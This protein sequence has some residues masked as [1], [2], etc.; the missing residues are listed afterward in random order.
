M[1]TTVARRARV[2]EGDVVAFLEDK[3]F[4]TLRRIDTQA[5]HIFLTED[6]AWKIKRP[7]D[8]GFLDFSSP[9]KRRQALEAELELNRRTAPDLYLGVHA[10]TRDISGKLALNGTG[11]AVDWVLE[12]RRFSDD[13]LLD[14]RAENHALNFDLL[15]RVADAVQRF[16]D[17]AEIAW[18]AVPEDDLRAVISGNDA[19]FEATTAVLLRERTTALTRAH[20]TM[21]RQC[22]PLLGVR[23]ARG[24]V[25]HVHGDL[26]LRNIAVIDGH[27]LLFDCLESDTRL[28]TIDVTYDLSFLLMDLWH[29]GLCNEANA[30]YNRYVDLSPEDED[31]GAL[32]PLF[33]SLRAAIRAH[34]LATQAL[35]GDD[36]AGLQAR[37]YLDQAIDLIRPVKPCLIALGGL[38]GTGK[39]TL[40]RSLGGLVGSAPGARI[41]R[42]DVLRK[43]AAG[44]KP[45]QSLPRSTYTPA[46]AQKSYTRL[47]DA[48]ARQLENGVS[49]IVD[50]AFAEAEQRQAIVQVADRADAPFEGLWL[51][52][53][54]ET[55]LQRVRRRAHDASDADEAVARMQRDADLEDAGPWRTLVTNGAPEQVAADARGLLHQSLT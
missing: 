44:L 31:A 30:V 27:T 53:G 34:V 54:I 43:R 35:Q 2:D 41:L 40:A 49:V 12:M 46:A 22:E 19:R 23:A 45:E 26:H 11:E 18:D 24:R 5:A 1:A 38:S 55:R 42:S 21:L 47:A 20:R 3:A 14:R 29:R 8:L 32:L 51:R 25:R 36:A 6:R 37:S 13:A 16:H 39:S 28:A 15:R 50:A 7:V 17:Q 9:A 4:G 33:L 48:A 10:V 52:A